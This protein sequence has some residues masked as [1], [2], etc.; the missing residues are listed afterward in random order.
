MS[1]H[2]ADI[3]IFSGSG[4]YEL[5]TGQVET[6]KVST[7]YG[8]PSDTIDICNINGV[9]VA[10]L[11]RHGKKHSIPP[12]S[13]NYRAN[14][15]AMKEL[16]VKRIIAPCACG[17]L[18]ANIHPGEFVVT[19]QFVDRTKNRKDTFSDGANVMHIS[20]AEPYCSQLRKLAI[21]AIEDEGAVVHEEG[22][23]VVINGPRFST[24]AESRWFTQMGWHTI[25]MTQYPEAVLAQELGICL[26][27]I[28]MITDYDAG[29][30]GDVP[31]VS[32]QAVFKT[33]KKTIDVL[34]RILIKLVKIIPEDKT[35][36]CKQKVE[37]AYFC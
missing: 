22:T 31:E 33:F 26:V 13:I 27:N 10:F 9:K 6:I 29:L 17:S 18:Q 21:A 32:A 23:M 19:D 24:K 35:C 11:P 16:G 36:R 7:P 20:S 14:L 25:N 3:G 8:S 30:V 1:K 34:H 12:H 37:E 2:S 4:M 15:W 28:A 5:T